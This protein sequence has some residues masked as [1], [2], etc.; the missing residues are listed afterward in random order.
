MSID[1]LKP[2]NFKTVNDITAAI[3]SL[4]TTN[5]NANIDISIFN[6]LDQKGFKELVNKS[7]EGNSPESI[8][9]KEIDTIGADNV[10]TV[11]DANDSKIIDESDFA[12]DKTK[13]TNS[14]T[15][16]DGDYQHFSSPELQ[17]VLYNILMKTLEMLKLINNK[18]EK[19]EDGQEVDSSYRDYAQSVLPT[20]QNYFNIPAAKDYTPLPA[21]YQAPAPAQISDAVKNTN[22]AVIADA[23]KYLGYNEG[24][25][26]YKK[27]TNGRTE[28]WCADFVTYVAKETYGDKLPK[29]FG[30]ASVS[31]LYQ[32][33][34]DNGKTVGFDR[35]KAGDVMIQK[36]NGAS[37]TGYVTAVDKD[38]T[39]H[40]IEG[41][42][43][44]QVAERTYKPGSSG[45]NKITCFISLDPVS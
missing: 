20:G 44:D 16:L 38:G 15:G 2:E 18:N 25:N 31:N 7:K 28:A 8:F 21:N 22:T 26:S 39:I 17:V 33:G 19:D 12:D 11:L 45:Y 6:G 23:R 30:S 34:K 40:T 9:F 3:D 42:T 1:N 10:F 41:N 43:S 32:W 13:K 36:S 24:D 4:K 5:S 35:V 37:H 29:G 14:P 27:F